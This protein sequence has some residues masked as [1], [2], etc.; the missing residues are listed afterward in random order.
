M[1]LFDELSQSALGGILNSNSAPGGNNHPLLS[2]VMQ[3]VQNHPGGLAGMVQSFQ[4]KGLG[5]LMSSWVSTGQNL[6][7]TADQVQHV[8]G[9]NQL[10]EIAAK[11]GLSP[12]EASSQLSSLLPMVIDKL[13]PN[14]QVSDSQ[15]LLA[16]MNLLKPSA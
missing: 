2:A 3:L 15:N 4:Q 5:D 6:P 9:H 13:T 11:A 12:A 16:A 1:G 7:I 10:Q 8:L 14:G